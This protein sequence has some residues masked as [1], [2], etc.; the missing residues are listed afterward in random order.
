MKDAQSGAA[1]IEVASSS[2]ESRTEVEQ[3]KRELDQIRKTHQWDPNLPQG[4]LDA[5]KHAL[6]HGDTKEILETEHLFA[7]NSPYEEVRA[8]VRPTDNG[9]V[10]NTVRAWIMGM[11]F[12]TI[13]SG[14]NMFLSM[15]FVVLKDEAKGNT[16]Y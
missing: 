9:E 15:R 10:A 12:V 13:G 8:A 1:E 3:A 6:E 2:S 16:S 4:K 5:V 14:L 7:D 11:F